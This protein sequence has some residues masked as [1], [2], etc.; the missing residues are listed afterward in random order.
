MA[1]S[2]EERC[3]GT[4]YHRHIRLSEGGAALIAV[5]N[6]YVELTSD[7]PYRE[8]MEPGA[9]AEALLAEVAA[10]RMPRDAARLILD[11]AGHRRE[12][13]QAALPDKDRR[14]PDPE[15]LPQDRH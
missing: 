10:G 8:A 3:D 4:G 9:A 12:V 5:A 13:S 1:C 2:V 15:H 6:Y 14:Q 7:L 11:S